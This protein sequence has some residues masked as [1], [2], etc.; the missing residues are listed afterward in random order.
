MLL[1]L[2]LLLFHRVF[3]IFLLLNLDKQ[4]YILFGHIHDLLQTQQKL[5]QRVSFH[6]LQV[7]QLF[8]SYP[9]LQFPFEKIYLDIFQQI[10]QFLLH[11]LNLHQV[12]QLFR[13]LNLQV[14]LQ[15]FLLLQSFFLQTLLLISF[16]CFFFN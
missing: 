11:Y 12:L 13:C 1:H 16:L 6:M 2:H 5:M 14:L 4:R 8:Q 7:Q 15:N 9:L 10:Y 3:R